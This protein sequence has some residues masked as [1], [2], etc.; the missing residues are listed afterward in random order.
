MM[1]HI[2]I[3]DDELHT[4]DMHRRETNRYAR[5]NSPRGYEYLVVI[6]TFT[7]GT[8]QFPC[9]GARELSS[10]LGWAS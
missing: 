4:I 10:P 7:K 2:T 6:I 3:D 5:Y 8:P 9:V 1:Q